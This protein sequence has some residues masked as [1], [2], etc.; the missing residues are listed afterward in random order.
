MAGAGSVVLVLV[1]VVDDEDLS[2]R[3]RRG[4]PGR[5]CGGSPTPAIRRAPASRFA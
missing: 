2:A 5:R 3:L 1:V 4:Q